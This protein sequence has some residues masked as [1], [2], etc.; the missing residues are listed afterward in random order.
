MK[1]ILVVEDTEAIREELC[2]I[3]RMEGFSVFEAENG[4]DALDIAKKEIPNLI[5]SDVL[6]PGLDGFQLYKEL[7]KNSETKEIP[8]IFLSAKANKEAIIKGLRMGAQDYII[9]P[10]SPDELLYAVNDKINKK[11]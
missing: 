8:F 10:V 4:L 2:D 7:E 11:M 9:K 1:N 3:L 6:M 5:I